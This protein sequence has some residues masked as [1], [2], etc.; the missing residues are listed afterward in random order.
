VA[1]GDFSRSPL[2]MLLASQKKGY[3]GLYIEQG[4]PILDRDLNLLQ[5]LLSAGMRSLFTRIVGNGV[6]PESDSFAIQALSGGAASQD[7]LIAAGDAPCIVNGIEVNISEALRYSKQKA[8]V[9]PLTA[10]T[11]A[12]PDLRIDTV[13][14]DVFLVEEDGANDTDLANLDDVGIRTSVRLKPAWTVRVAEDSPTMPEPRDGHNFYKLAELRRPRLKDAI[15][16]TMI[17]DH[18]QRLLT[19]ADL[20]GRLRKLE[21]VLLLPAFSSPPFDLPSGLIGQTINLNGTNFT[22]G[23][24]SSVTVLFA[25]RPA[26]FSGTASE[27]V[28][29]VKVPAEVVPTGTSFVDVKITVRTAGG[30]VVSDVTFRAARG[31]TRPAPTFAIPPFSPRDGNVDDTIELHGDNF[32]WPTTTVKFGGANQPDSV[33]AKI[34]GALTHTLIKVKVPA[35]VAPPGS[36]RDI[37]ITVTTGGGSVESPSSFRVNG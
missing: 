3:I 30:E 29:Q 27:T 12:Q 31:P 7:F 6:P 17:T 33:T 23:G 34:V 14:L 25:D 16:A 35:G 2:T 9:D 20:D 24:A 28:L 5:D 26:Q 18:R 21:R 15:E 36:A 1:D 11:S 8:K 32:N 37:P 19:V 10:P 13:F 4:V 22:V